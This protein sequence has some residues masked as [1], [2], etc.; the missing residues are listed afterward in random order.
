MLGAFFILR[1]KAF[2]AIAKRFQEGSIYL[3]NLGIKLLL[4]IYKKGINM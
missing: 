4:I 3:I 2:G 1:M